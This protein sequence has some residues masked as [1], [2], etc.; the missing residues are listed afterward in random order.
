MAVPVQD[1][2]L[3]VQD[4]IWLANNLVEQLKTRWTTN[5]P[6]V[7]DILDRVAGWAE[8][9]EQRIHLLGW[10][11]TRTDDQVSALKNIACTRTIT[12]MGEDFMTD[13]VELCTT[14]MA[15]ERSDNQTTQDNTTTYSM[16]GD[17]HLDRGQQQ[18][19][20]HLQHLDDQRGAH[21]SP[22]TRRRGRR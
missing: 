13:V 10:L 20:H 5:N 6:G 14:L 8:V 22:S 12:K 18:Q 4:M 9:H 11:A 17:N 15:N 3:P 2:S 21:P 19:L 1:M 16:E 7:E